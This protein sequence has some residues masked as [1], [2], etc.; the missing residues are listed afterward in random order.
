MNK[1]AFKNQEHYAHSDLVELVELL[2]S[3][4]GCPWDRAQTH[5]SVRRGV[6]EEAYEVAEAIDCADPAMMTEEL[7]DLLMQVVFHISLGE[8]QGT[9]TAEQVYDRVCRKLIF[10]HPHIFADA[11]DASSSTED[12]WA[13]I[14]RQ[15][16][17]QRTL[18]EDLNGIAK[19]LPALTRAEKIAGKVYPKEHPD[20]EVLLKAAEEMSEHP[21]AEKLG[22][23]LFAAARLAKALKIDP[24]DAL[25]KENQRVIDTNS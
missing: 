1:E 13:A 23:L 19:T 9:F 18:G 20:T 17:G 25:R 6:I 2:R 14:K 11:P 22:A 8:Q 15:E 3:P 4:D 16:K 10:R 7:G 24:E 12:G 5:Q 21:N